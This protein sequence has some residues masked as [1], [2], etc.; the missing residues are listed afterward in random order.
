MQPRHNERV[1]Q[2]SA[3]FAASM[4]EEIARLTALQAINPSVRNEEIETLR[5]YQEQ[6]LAM[7]GKAA[8]RLEAIRVLVAG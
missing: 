3:A 5:A 1:A 8:L 4:N 7:F 6:G 2:A